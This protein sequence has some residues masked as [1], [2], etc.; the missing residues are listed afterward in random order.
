MRNSQ[1]AG[2]F[3]VARAGTPLPKVRMPTFKRPM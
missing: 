2:W 3:R 1:K